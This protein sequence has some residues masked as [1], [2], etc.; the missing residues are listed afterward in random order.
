[1]PNEEREVGDW[2]VWGMHVLHELRRLNTEQKHMNGNIDSLLAFRTE[3]RA[4][5]K[6]SAIMVSS[7]FGLVSLGVTIFVAL[8]GIK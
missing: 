4:S 6:I 1:M 2:K 5:A 8:H 3:A 7:V